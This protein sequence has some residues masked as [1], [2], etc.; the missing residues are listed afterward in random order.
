MDEVLGDAKGTNDLG[1]HMGGD[2]YAAELEY[3]VAREFARN[4][5]DVLRRRSKLYLHLDG[6]A[7]GRVAAWLHQRG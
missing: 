2:L 4:A 5:E 1:Q 7:Q 6:D 3:L